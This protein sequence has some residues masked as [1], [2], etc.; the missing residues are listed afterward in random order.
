MW[1]WR[2]IFFLL[3]QGLLVSDYRGGEAVLSA[4]RKRHLGNRPAGML[5]RYNPPEEDKAPKNPASYVISCD[6]GSSITDLD[7]WVEAVITAGIQVS[8][9][10]VKN[11][12]DHSTTIYQF[13]A[14]DIDLN[15][16]DFHCFRDRVVL[17]V[18]TAAEC[19]RF[20]EVMSLLQSIYLRKSHLGL[21]IM[22]F[23][24]NSFGAQEPGTSAEIKKKY[25]A[26][27]SFP[28]F[29]RVKVNGPRAHPLFRFLTHHLPGLMGTPVIRWNF[30]MFLV[31]AEGI[32]CQRFPST[33]DLTGLESAI[34]A[35]L[36]GV[37]SRPSVTSSGSIDG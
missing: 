36:V 28:L 14:E 22:A 33:A 4:F 26:L 1:C 30:E 16:I 34:N 8:N 7:D 15:V 32:P 25:E 18:N 9:G 31:S 12:S 10:P 5:I 29:S 21:T 23:P 13:F 19:H 20:A 35:Q 24:C 17:I 37:S 11:L 3:T 6:P 27:I 2:L